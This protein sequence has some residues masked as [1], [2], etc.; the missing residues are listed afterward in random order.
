M[1]KRLGFISM[2]VA[3]IVFTI[4]GGCN[5]GFHAGDAGGD[6][7]VASN[8]TIHMP[9]PV[10]TDWLC[11]QGAN[12]YYS[13][14][15][16][17]T[18][19][20]L[21]L[22]TPNAPNPL[23]EVYAPA[24]GTAH[25]FNTSGFGKHVNIDLGDGTYIVLPHLNLVW[26]TDNTYVQQGQ[27]VGLAG[28]TGSCNGEHVHLDL[29]R[30]LANMPAGNGTSI[31]YNV[32]ARD[33]TV[34]GYARAIPV[35]EFV[36]SLSSGHRYESQLPV[37][38]YGPEY[39]GDDDDDDDDYAGDDDGDDDDDDDD[40]SSSDDDDVADDDDTSSGDDDDDDSTPAD[41]DDVSGDDD[42]SSGD[43]DDDDA[44]SGDD[45]DDS[46]SSGDD[47]DDDISALSHGDLVFTWIDTNVWARLQMDGT[48]N[49][50]PPYTG[51]WSQFAYETNLN[52]ITRMIPSVPRNSYAAV[53]ISLSMN[54]NPANGWSNMACYTGSA[55]WTTL[56][57]LTA[58]WA[59]FPLT[60]GTVTDGGSGCNLYVVSP[61]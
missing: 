11:T 45:D 34:G 60:V 24:A 5:V 37:D 32:F 55:G 50:L 27:A 56:G 46:T 31:P 15:G 42:T 57:T 22:D 51:F 16:N 14:T 35:E 59:G 3:V 33:V 21:D 38:I 28:C 19:Y 25:V 13:H 17:S 23:A 20:G 26:T 9:F 43:D 10:G 49:N 4:F 44:S 53:N 39:P 36:C 8:T 40:T 2:M 29:H 1:T 30:G 47:D 41:D 6:A 18:R 48:V 52:V 54:S 7:V 58:T 61:P 12:G